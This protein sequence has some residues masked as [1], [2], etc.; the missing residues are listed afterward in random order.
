M[1][2]TVN[3]KLHLAAI[4]FTLAGNINGEKITKQTA[5]CCVYTLVFVLTK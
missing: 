2:V 3:T 4:W 1:K 5:S